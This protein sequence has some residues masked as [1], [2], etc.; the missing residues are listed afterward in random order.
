TGTNI[1]DLLNVGGITWGWFQ[2]GFKPDSRKKDGTAVCSATH[3]TVAAFSSADYIPHHEPFQYYVSTANRHHLPPTSV[4]MIGHTDQAKH[5]Y[6]LS[7]FWAAADS[8]NLPAVSFLKAAAYQD[9]HAENSDPLDEQ[10]FLVQTINHLQRLQEWPGIAVI[11][12][13]D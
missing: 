2:G 3:T 12:A 6:D 4:S 9:A 7:D 8:G 5:Q 1:G 11:I 13:Y 10:T